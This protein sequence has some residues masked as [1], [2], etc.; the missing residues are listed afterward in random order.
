MTKNHVAALVAYS[1]TTWDSLFVGKGRLTT[2]LPPFLFSCVKE[3]RG[4]HRSKRTHW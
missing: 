2:P 1:H 3:I 4:Q